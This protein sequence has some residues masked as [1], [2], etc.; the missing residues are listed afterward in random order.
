MKESRN[1]NFFITSLKALT[2]VTAE[3]LQKGAT[4][5]ALLMLM[6]T[7]HSFSYITLFNFFET[8]I[9][10]NRCQKTNKIYKTTENIFLD[11][12]V[13]KILRNI[14]QSKVPVL[15]MDYRPTIESYIC[16]S[17]KEKRTDK[18]IQTLADLGRCEGRPPLGPISFIFMQFLGKS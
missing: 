18:T 2:T 12:S 8:K 10:S 15:L 13:R 1:I 14:K 4:S 9:F 5:K 3:L 11:L 7:R 16:G 17:I 6:S